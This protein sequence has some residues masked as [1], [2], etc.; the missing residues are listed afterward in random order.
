MASSRKKNITYLY[1]IHLPVSLRLRGVT[2]SV[3]SEPKI[4]P[5]EINRR[6]HA[7]SPHVLQ[8]KSEVEIFETVKA[9]KKEAV[10][11]PTFDEF[12][13]DFFTNLDSKHEL[14]PTKNKVVPENLDSSLTHG[15][16]SEDDL[17]TSKK[18]FNLSLPTLPKIKW[19]TRQILPKEAKEGIELLEENLQELE[20]NV[21]E[22]VDVVEKEAKKKF[23]KTP[24]L[25]SIKFTILHPS[26]RGISVFVLLSFV[27]VLPLQ[28]MNST[29]NAST[30]KG[31]VISESTQALGAFEKAAEATSR[32]DFL[33]AKQNFEEA[34]FL[35]SGAQ[36]ALDELGAGTKVLASIIPSQEGRDLKTGQALLDMGRELS[37][38]AERISD[39]FIA[40]SNLTETS[41]GTKVEVL[42]RY[43]ES[44]LPH[45]SSANEALSRIKEDT[46]PEEFRS[47]YLQLS[48]GL[49]TLET[50]LRNLQTFS[51]A[52][53]TILGNEKKQR[54]LFVFQN[55]T[56]IR[57]TG[58]FIG[59]FAEV[60]IYRGEIESINLPGDGSYNLQGQLLSHVLAPEP[61]QLIN[62]RWE[63]QDANWFPDFKTSAEKLLWFHNQAGGPTMDGVIS[64]NAS[65]VADLL[66]LLGPIEMNG[67]NRTIDSENFLIETQ[68]IVELEYD[69]EENKPKQFLSDLAPKLI[70]RL[71]EVDQN[72]FLPLLTYLSR[73][74]SQKDIQLY[75]TDPEAQDA[76]T[77]LGWTGEI[78]RTTGDYLM[79]VNANI[80][81]Q[82][83]DA[84]IDET[85]DLDST[86]LENGRIRNTVTITR[87]HHGISGALF[88]GAN[89]V[90][91]V[92]L[93]VPR[94]SRLIEMTGATP[95]LDSQFEERE[96]HLEEDEDLAFI[97]ASSVTEVAGTNVSEML[98]KTV[99]GN[100]VQTKPGQ[101]STVSFT[102]ELPWKIEWNNDSKS[103]LEK[104]GALMGFTSPLAHTLT[105][106]PQSGMR[107][108][109][110]NASISFPDEK[111][112]VWSSG[113]IDNSEI[114]AQIDG[115]NSGFIAILFDE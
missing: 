23:F 63:F 17:N 93:L 20:E 105:I 83:T 16:L 33:S 80:G 42:E 1:D 96:S 13:K 5:V 35:I 52:L 107:G 85:V 65:F 12:A 53:N 112:P 62:S 102:Y 106:D 114:E 9:P 40:I 27:F 56:E 99:F 15:Q 89:N 7:T 72:N 66:E 104:A 94:G 14:A 71:T 90:N 24:K 37:I 78:S 92:Q 55:D 69:T 74:L 3:K 6:H 22:L 110:V 111:T 2:K 4:T 38:S 98:G 41:L 88:T 47:H 44:A 58:G 73:G 36:E 113:L 59:S 54:Y 49:P 51:Q 18:R 31:Q 19:P 97:K 21:L 46:I 25:P 75:F 68:K 60:D 11:E 100:W 79:V 82:K 103:F 87:H 70:E 28:A 108:R 10:S 43:L 84:V 81:G 34:S 91:Y 29:S 8:L 39:G 30:I 64:I 26:L 86:I 76:I 77:E 109:T 115:T 61:L 48:Q 95:P 101:I 50:G 57:P 67:Y 32:V 45:I